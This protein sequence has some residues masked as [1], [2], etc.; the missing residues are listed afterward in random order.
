MEDYSDKDM[1]DQIEIPDDLIIVDL[2]SANLEEALIKALG[3]KKDE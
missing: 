1:L 2:S 3:C